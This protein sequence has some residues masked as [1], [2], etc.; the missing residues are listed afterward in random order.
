MQNGLNI[1]GLV[2][3]LIRVIFPKKKK[4]PIAYVDPLTESLGVIKEL[5]TRYPDNFYTETFGIP[6]EKVDDFIYFAKDNAVT[7]QLVEP[8]NEMELLET[9]FQQSERYKAETKNE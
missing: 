4:N 5:Q 3:L 1:K 2:E 6:A 7:K 9:L 8:G